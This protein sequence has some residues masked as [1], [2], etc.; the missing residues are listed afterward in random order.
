MDPVP[1]EENKEMFHFIKMNIFGES[2][3]GKSSLISWLEKYNDDTFKIKADIRDSMNSSIEF[4]QNLVEQVK[5]VKVPFTLE[6]NIYFLLYETNLNDFD[7]IKSNLDTLLIQTECIVL[8]WDKSNPCT[9]DRLPDLINIITP[10]ISKKVNIYLVENKT[11][12]IFDINNEGKSEREIEENI[13]ML[14]KQYHFLYDLQIS[15]I[16][17]DGVQNILLSIDQNYKPETKNTD[18]AENLV[19]IPYPMK[20][21]NPNS[22]TKFINI[23]IIG[24][25]QTGKSTFIEK[26]GDKLGDNNNKLELNYLIE[27]CDEKVVIKILDSSAKLEDKALID[28]IY[29]KCHGFL[30]F[31]DV[32]NENSFNYMEHWAKNIQENVIGKIIIVANKIDKRGKKGIAKSKGKNFAKE[33]N[34]KYFE[35]SCIFGININ[36]I[37][38][39]ISLISYNNY[40]DNLAKVDTYSLREPKEQIK[41][42]SK[43]KCC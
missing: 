26:L 12:L 40:K 2:R 5:K 1:I 13:E 35:C 23:C 8:M 42:K 25:K 28:T 20:E 10:M 30:L 41:G 22:V 27:I 3:V 16:N 6:K 43:S 31:F 19:K 37:F 17:K 18:K 14:K 7:K 34:C 9:F 24:D 36:E 11:D 33:M 4:S 38:K 15:L 29:K 39:E 32:T 21:I